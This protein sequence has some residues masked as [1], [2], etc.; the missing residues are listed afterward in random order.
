MVLF[1]S[2]LEKQTNITY[3]QSLSNGSDRRNYSVGKMNEVI[4]HGTQ[5]TLLLSQ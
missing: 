5:K 1:T 2:N 3:I 4:K